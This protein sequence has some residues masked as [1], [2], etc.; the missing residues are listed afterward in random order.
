[1][2]KPKI[3]I[4]TI[5]YNCASKIE[6]TIKSVIFQKY[7]NKE[8]IIIDGASTDGTMEVVDRYKDFID[9][10]VS[11]PD[12]GRSDA[13][14]KGIEKATGE[15]IVMMNAGDLLAEDALNKFANA[16]EPGYDVIKGNTI[17][18]NAETGFKSV[19]RPV[20]NYPSIPWNFLV[21]HQSTYISKSAYERFGG[22]LVDM[23]IVMDFELMLR[24]TQLGAKFNS[25]DEDLAVFRMGG[26]SQTSSKRRYEE[27][28][29]AMLKNGHSHINTHIFI[30][31]VKIRTF[32][33]NLL[34][35]INPDLKNIVITKKCNVLL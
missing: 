32:L 8:Y 31:Y 28:R 27:L 24:F 2:K 35:Q 18:W 34:N 26:I 19:E 11:E 25:I 4:V 3:S 9:V 30:V 29:Y 33:R 15:Y 21:C 17:R 13:F 5:A 23:R 10:I 12:K 6:D 22:Y 16:F 1:M 7:D 20:I 14:N